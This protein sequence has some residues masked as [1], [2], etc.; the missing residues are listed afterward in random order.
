M[1]AQIKS[2]QNITDYQG[3]LRGKQQFASGSGFKPIWMPDFL[4]A[5]T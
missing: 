4:L 1:K 2:E 3:F 5:L